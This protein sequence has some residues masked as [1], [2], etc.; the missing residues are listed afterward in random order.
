M[1]VVYK[2]TVYFEFGV[3]TDWFLVDGWY[4]LARWLVGTY[5]FLV[6]CWFVFCWFGG[7]F[8]FDCA[9]MFVCWFL[10]RVCFSCIGIILLI[11]FR[12]RLGC[13]LWFLLW[14]LLLTCC[15][16]VCFVVIVCWVKDWLF[17]YDCF[18]MGCL[19]DFILV[20]VLGWF[21][22]FWIWLRLCNM[23]FCW[24]VVVKF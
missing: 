20:V 10:Q 24:G 16:W 3:A 18:L 12:V 9:L 19:V 7:C 6:G 17:D 15:M 14:G 22:T 11:V 13:L 23:L 1:L 2:F 8:M 21:V 5:W 4:V